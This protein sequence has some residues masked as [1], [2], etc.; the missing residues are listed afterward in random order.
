[1]HRI[2]AKGL[3]AL[4]QH[5]S[6]GCCGNTLSP[7]WRHSRWEVRGDRRSRKGAQQCH[8]D[9]WVQAGRWAVSTTAFPRW[10]PEAG[11]PPT[12]QGP[13]GLPRD[14]GG[15]RPGLMPSDYLGREL[16]SCWG[17]ILGQRAAPGSSRSFLIC[18]PG[19]SGGDGQ[20]GRAACADG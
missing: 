15:K 12:A 17:W 13:V 2:C 10:A 1:M 5:Q 14:P 20:L 18:K 9:A 16:G 7:E 6:P 3:F 11:P 4:L 8:V 19:F